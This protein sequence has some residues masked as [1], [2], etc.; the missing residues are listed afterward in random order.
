M[1]IESI[2]LEL[3]EE[4]IST[5]ITKK[6]SRLQKLNN[7]KEKLR[8]INKIAAIVP[9]ISMILTV[10]LRN[11]TGTDMT[12]MTSSIFGDITNLTYTT[13]LSGITSL[14]VV[15]PIFMINSLDNSNNEKKVLERDLEDLQSRKKHIQKQLKQKAKEKK[16]SLSKSKEKKESIQNYIKSELEYEI[17]YIDDNDISKTSN[18]LYKK[19]HN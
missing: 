11:I 3:E 12:E 5:E 1:D 8:N 2:L 19:K 17:K 16:H 18:N 4:D 13:L 15:S 14:A 7:N 6:N 10:I 9:V